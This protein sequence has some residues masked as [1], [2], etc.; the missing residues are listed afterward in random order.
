LSRSEIS[1]SAGKFELLD[2]SLENDK[3]EAAQ[4]LCQEF[5]SVIKKP[6][7]YLVSSLLPV[8]SGFLRA[9]VTPDFF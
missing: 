5:C 7:Y 9:F 2:S 3:L 8:Y 1:D 4:E 6:L